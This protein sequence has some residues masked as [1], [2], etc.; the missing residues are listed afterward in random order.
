VAKRQA[1][2]N[3]ENTISRSSGSWVASTTKSA[4]NEDGAYQVVRASNGDV[5]IN[6]NGKEYRRPRSPHDLQKLKQAAEE[7][8]G[9]PISKVVV[10]VPAYFTTPSGRRQGRRSDRRLEIMR[11]VNE[12][13]PPRSRTVSTRKRTRHRGVMTSA[14]AHST[15]RSS[16]S[17]GRR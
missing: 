3:P 13:T 2:T 11:I 12:P 1:V 9:E 17:G 10:T 15:S 8:L 6:A 14:A 4:K 16:K 5:R 7:Y